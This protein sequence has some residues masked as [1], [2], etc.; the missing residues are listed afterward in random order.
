VVQLARLALAAAAGAN[1]ATVD[2][3]L[4]ERAWCELLPGDS[5]A[6]AP[7]ATVAAATTPAT[8]RPVRRLWS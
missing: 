3:E 1:M 8:V 7:Q 2:P 6:P 5:P 4:V